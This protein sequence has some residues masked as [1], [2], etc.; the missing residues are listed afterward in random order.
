MF[1]SILLLASITSQLFTKNK[2]NVLPVIFVILLIIS[3]LLGYPYFRLT[4]YT[5]G[6]PVILTVFVLLYSYEKVTIDLKNFFK[7]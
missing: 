5:Y 7:K 2:I 1:L 4:R 6:T 3:D